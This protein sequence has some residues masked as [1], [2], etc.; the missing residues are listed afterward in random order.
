MKKL[1]FILLVL[2]LSGC[3]GTYYV[4]E[5]DR[6]NYYPYQRGYWNS[7]GYTYVINKPY[8]HHH[9]HKPNKPNNHNR[10]NRPN[11]PNN[12]PSNKIKKR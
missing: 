9:I 12:K 7:W 8:H 3:A 4:V 2:I 10:P 5:E 11:K 6:Y 1:L